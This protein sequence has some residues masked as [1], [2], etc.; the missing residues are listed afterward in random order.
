MMSNLVSIITPFFN[1]EKFIAEAIQSVLDQQHGNWELILIND[2]STDRS[3]EIVFYYKDKRIRYFEKKNEG[4]STARNVGLAK[5]RGDYFC[6]LDADDKLTINSLSDRLE[7][8]KRHPSS[9]FVDGTVQKFNHD[10]NELID[11]WKPS[12]KGQ[13]LQDLLKLSGKSF[14]GPTWMIKREKNIIYSMKEVLTHG[15]DLFFYLQLSRNLNAIYNY[16]DQV[17]LH[18]RIHSSSAMRSDYRKLENGYRMI[19]KF[20]SSWPEVSK[21]QRS[22]YFNRTRKIMF[23]SYLSRLQVVKALISLR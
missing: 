12:F 19:Y 9:S 4:V 23:K 2:G 21:K 16:T 10:F 8:F 7:V 22:I 15:E 6:F 18:Y 13:P 14:F 1:A 20:I 5:M 17:I 11:V 3:K